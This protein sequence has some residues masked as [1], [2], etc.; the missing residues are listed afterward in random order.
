MGV[1]NS[2][3]ESPQRMMLL[4]ALRSRLCAAPP[5]G[6]RPGA[7]G[8]CQHRLCPPR[9][10]TKN[11]V[12][13]KGG[14]PLIPAYRGTT[15]SKLPNYYR[16]TSNPRVPGNHSIC[17]ALFLKETFNRNN[18]TKIDK[19]HPLKAGCEPVY[20]GCFPTNCSLSGYNYLDFKV[21]Q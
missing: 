19:L 5:A 4:E 17:N 21:E 10:R 11:Y 2:Y 18:S 20:V 15:E 6:A 7:G 12:Y 9:K 8:Q 13:R 16:H 14:R 1:I 3:C